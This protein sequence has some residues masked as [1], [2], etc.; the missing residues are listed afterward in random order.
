[1]D[2][3]GMGPL[4][5]LLVLIVGLLVL[6]PEKLPA[7]AAK[8]GELYRKLTK[9]TSELSKSI[10]EEISAETK[11]ASEVTKSITEEISAGAR[12]ISELGKSITQEITA[13]TKAKEPKKTPP[14]TAPD[15]KTAK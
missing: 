2:F 7:M 8:A 4:E 10:T 13:E 14:T 3:M 12:A 11:A 9:A 15:E 5:I 1:M 6:G